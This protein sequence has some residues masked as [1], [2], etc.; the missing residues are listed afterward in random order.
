MASKVSIDSEGSTELAVMTTYS[1]CE[2]L[3]TIFS[4]VAGL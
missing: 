1:N 2:L 3:R 4:S